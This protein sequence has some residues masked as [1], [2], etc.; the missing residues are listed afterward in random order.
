[1]RPLG[2]A[3]VPGAYNEPL[4]GQLYVTIVTYE[5]Y[6]LLSKKKKP[7]CEYAPLGLSQTVRGK[8]ALGLRINLHFYCTRPLSPASVSDI[9]FNLKHKKV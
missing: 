7:V 9:N 3:T 2:R 8:I 6:A 5:L 1:M 4:Y